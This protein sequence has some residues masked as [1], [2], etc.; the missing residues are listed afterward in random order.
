M[1]TPRIIE[2][3]PSDISDILPFRKKM[4]A[5]EKKAPNAAGTT[6]IGM[7][8]QLLNVRQS[9]SRIMSREI[10]TVTARSLLTHLVLP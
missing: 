2:P 3:I 4:Q 7:N 1:A 5:N 9:T 8:D 10:P 6:F